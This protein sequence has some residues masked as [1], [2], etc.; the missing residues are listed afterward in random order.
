M[1]PDVSIV[2]PNF[3]GA[4]L[5]AYNLPS[6]FAA[7]ETY[8]QGTQVIVVDDGSR[9]ASLKVL[10]QQ[11]PQAR[12][13]VHPQNKGFAEAV[14]SGISAAQSELI[15]LLNSDVQP[16]PDCLEALAGYFI[17]PDTFAVSPLIKDEQEKINRHSWNIRRFQHG[18]LKPVQW[19]LKEAIASRQKGKLPTIYASGGSV[20]LRKSMFMELGGFNPLFKPFYGEDY[21]LGLRA[22]RRGWRSY[23]EPSVSVIHQHQGSIKDNVKRAYVKLIRRRNK[24]VLEWMHL[25]SWRLWTSVIPL[26]IWQLLGELVLLDKVNVK[27]FW[28]ALPRIPVVLRERRGLAHT[29]KLSMNQVLEQVTGQ[30]QS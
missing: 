26:S 21:D 9:D 28:S 16:G 19:D 14:Y 15:F 23:F 1:K 7:A 24:L 13:I 20:M 27:G 30:P 6:V 25:P 11:F 8:K 22:W 2:I 3:D 17:E 4:A 5:L 29:Q 10:E 18:Q 12:V